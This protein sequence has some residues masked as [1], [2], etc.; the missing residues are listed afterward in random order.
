VDRR[1]DPADGADLLPELMSGAAAAALRAAG[2]P[3]LEPTVLTQRHPDRP[4]LRWT[5][6]N[7]PVVVKTFAAGSSAEQ[8]YATMTALWESPFGSG[9]N[10]P[11]LPRPLALVP[12]QRAVVMSE[13]TGRTLAE[14]GELPDPGALPAVGAL[15]ADLQGSGAPLTRRRS[16][17]ALV[18]SV[19]RKA[20]DRAGTVMGPALRA[21]AD[22]L[23]RT[24]PPPGPLVPSHGDFSPRNVLVT[25]A[26]LVL[27]DWDR[28]LLAPPGRDVA[29]FGA[30]MWA[31]ELLEDGSAS[32]AAADEL[33]EGYQKL[34]PETDVRPEIAFHRACALG[35][36]AHGWSLFAADPELA[37]PVLDEAVRLVRT[38]DG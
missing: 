9:R 34:R 28:S 10:P 8:L 30:W 12:D 29:Y 31:T 18:R 4:V 17:A 5:T 23:A 22:L 13:V 7:G 21:L 33:V 15:L 14:R 2:V 6:T 16:A 32:W 38:V 24:V 35:R 37:L 36:I 20:T 1:N 19:E 11:G 25:E 26:G 27:I 3:V